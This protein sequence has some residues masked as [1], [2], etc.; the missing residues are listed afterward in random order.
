MQAIPCNT[1]DDPCISQYGYDACCMKATAVTVPTDDSSV[2][3][4]NAADAMKLFG[5]PINKG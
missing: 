2:S 4:E 1:S 3:W 5:L